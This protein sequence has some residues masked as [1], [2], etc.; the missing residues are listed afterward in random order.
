MCICV[1]TYVLCI[2]YIYGYNNPLTTTIPRGNTRKTFPT[3]DAET[4]IITKF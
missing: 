3:S 1:C 2:R 4:S